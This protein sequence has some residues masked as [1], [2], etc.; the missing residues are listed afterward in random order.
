MKNH[1]PHP[2]RFV[3]K[4]SLLLSN[5]VIFFQKVSLHRALKP[6]DLK[7][8]YIHPKLS[9]SKVKGYALKNTCKVVV[10]VGCPQS[11]M[12]NIY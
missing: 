11:V 5:M 9:D 12:L 7:N 8:Y 1:Q 4:T 10:I 2:V 3:L 6:I